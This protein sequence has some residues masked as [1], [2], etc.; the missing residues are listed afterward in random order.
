MVHKRYVWKNGIRHGPYYYES[1]REDG[2]VKKRYLGSL[3]N[4]KGY[5]WAVIALITVALLGLIIYMNAGSTGKVVLDFGDDFKRVDVLE[6]T[7]QLSVREGELLPGDTV[8]KVD[9]GGESRNFL[10]AELVSFVPVGGNYYVEGTSISGIGTGIG[11]AGQKI[12]Y[13]EVDFK[14]LISEDKESS[15]GGGTDDRGKSEEARAN[16]PGQQDNSGLENAPGQ[17]DDGSAPG[18]ADANANAGG[19]SENAQGEQA[20]PDASSNSNANSNANGN[21]N[22]NAGGNSESVQGRGR[23][24]GNLI[25]EAVIAE[26]ERAGYGKDERIV[27]GSVSKD[28]PFTYELG[29]RESASLIYGSVEIDG[30][31]VNEGLIS[32]NNEDNMVKVTTDYEVVEEGFGSDFIGENENKFTINL[33]ALSINPGQGDFSISLIRNDITIVKLD[34][35][36]E[37]TTPLSNQTENLTLLNDIPSLRVGK[38]KSVDVDLS[39]YFS[40]AQNYEL[41]VS[42]NISFSVLGNIMTITPDSEFSGARQAKISATALGIGSIESNQFNILVSAGNIEIKTGRS[43]IRLGEKVRWQKNFTT[44]TA[45]NVTIELP[46]EAENV[47]V[48]KV[49]D[50]GKQTDIITEVVPV[51]ANVIEQGLFNSILSF[52]IKPSITGRAVDDVSADTSAETPTEVP[53]ENIGSYE[54]EVE[55]TDEDLSDEADSSQEVVVEY[56]T[57]APEAFEVETGEDSGKVKEVVISAPDALE[58]TDVL[59]FTTIPEVLK[60]GQEGLVK[61]KWKENNSYIPADIYDI[62]GNELLD[63]IEWITPHLSNQTFEIIYITNALHLDENKTLIADVYEYVN[64]EDGINYTIPAN[65]YLRVTFEKNLTSSNDI[66]IYASSIGGTV[67]VYEKDS[68][69]KIADFGTIGEYGKK[70][71]ILTNL[72]GQQD[73]FDLLV[74]NG[75]VVFDYVVDPSV[76]GCGNISAPGIYTLSQYISSSNSCM[77]INV[78]DVILE[79]QTGYGIAYGSGGSG[80]GVKI[81]NAT[82][83]ISNI[84]IRNIHINKTGTTNTATSKGILVGQGASNVTIVN[85]SINNFAEG[86]IYYGI[87]VHFESSNGRRAQSVNITG[88]TIVTSG[89][90]NQGINFGIHLDQAGN[91]SIIFGNNISTTG[92]STSLGNDGMNIDRTY[93]VRIVNNNVTYSGAGTSGGTGTMGIRV[94][95]DGGGHNISNN[96]LRPGT[97]KNTDNRGIY[98]FAGS[99]YYLY[100]NTILDSPGNS[101]DISGG[102]AVIEKGLINNTSLNGA[103]VFISGSASVTLINISIFNTTSPSYDIKSSTSGVVSLKDMFDIGNYSFSGSTSTSRLNVNNSIYGSIRFLQ[104]VSAVGTNFTLDVVIANNSAYIN[105]SKTE[106]NRS[107]NITLYGIGDRGYTSPV[108]LRDGTTACSSTTSPACSNFTALTATNV[109]FN[110]SSWSNYS[111]GEDPA[112]LVSSCKTISSAG[113]YTLTQNIS[114][115]KSCITIS[116]SDVVLDG[117]GYEITYALSSSG[118]GTQSS[119]YSNVTIQNIKITKGGINGQTYAVAFRSIGQARLLNS[120]LVASGNINEGVLLYQPNAFTI[121]NNSI[122]TSGASGKGILVQYTNTPGTITNNSVVTEGSSSEAISLRLSNFTT[123]T[124]NSITTKAAFSPAFEIYTTNFNTTLEKNFINSTSD[125]SIWFTDSITQFPGYPQTLYAN[126]IIDNGFAQLESDTAGQLVSV[127]LKD[128]KIANY[129]LLY[130]GIRMKVENST[131]GLIDFRSAVNGTGVNLFG[132]STS[133]IVIGN[134]SVYVNPSVAGMGLNKS[135]NITLYGIGDR[136]FSNIG[137]LRNGV[138]CGTICYNFTSLTATNVIFNVSSWSTYSIGNA[139]LLRNVSLS[140]GW[141]F[142]A[143]EANSSVA[144]NKTVELVAGWNLV[145]YSSDTSIGHTAVTYKDSASSFYQLSSAA[146]NSK[147]QYY[148]PYFNNS[149]GKKTY[150]NLGLDTTG[151]SRDAAYWVYAQTPGNITFPAS[152]GSNETATVSWA[153]LQFN[154]GTDTVDTVAATDKDW[155][156][157]STDG[158][159]TVIR[160]WNPVAEAFEGVP[161]DTNLG[162]WDGYII[163]SNTENLT[164]IVTS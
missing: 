105:G 7:L 33:T 79:G 47:F 38:G 99:G 135:A 46:K 114:S 25:L 17:Q 159:E 152:S 125:S 50:D 142:F 68:G 31:K 2:E 131:N 49:E 90:S 84:T 55:I 97:L 9:Y 104:N 137:V 117:A 3:S 145:G 73:T 130:A 67:E 162:A 70:Q 157:I 20:S 72:V 118:N 8:L 164:M 39:Q 158:Y 112:Y 10:L 16:A 108:I 12:I 115:A 127:Y 76:T 150:E 54:I 36:G 85:V 110:V 18:Q 93:R 126:N 101:I 81:F 106:L 124:N 132:N 160:K 5:A 155:I 111:I 109:I 37:L 1:Y 52:F 88:N 77:Q 143:V 94:D 53:A 22:A 92:N 41:N 161:S 14:I 6:G 28:D 43:E 113:T 11:F 74:K 40:G 146:Q 71:V 149:I 91:D 128:Q 63:Y 48:K 123:V 24:T 120:I 107:A 148:F 13:P 23:A 59:S 122:T 35:A 30:E 66:T 57:V 86:Q 15:S 29:E 156:G 82:N 103:A 58:Y 121:L 42:S 96:L 87:H 44:D 83:T 34:Q 89:A 65:N 51:T 119:G 26:Q 144:G 129:S 60:V 139:P 4:S 80:V 163:W 151:F 21:G 134:N 78:G 138:S 154:N 19:N 100:N 45:D 98:I 61:I 116:A 56:E 141:N 102:D 69:V 64:A 27:E 62:D 133:D 147:L 95:N 153:S 136:G 140:S 75:E 32:L